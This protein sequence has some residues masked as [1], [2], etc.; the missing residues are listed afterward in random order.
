[1]FSLFGK[2]KNIGIDL[3]TVNTAVCLEKEGI[4]LREPTVVAVDKN[5]GRVLA[6]GA[7]ADEMLGR[8]PENIIAIRPL[9]DGVTADY[10]VACE[11]LKALM[12]KACGK[13]FIK[14]N[15]IVCVPCGITDVE[16]KAAEDAIVSAGAKKAIVV[17][18][19]MAAAVGAGAEVKKPVGHMIADIGGG[20]TEAAVIS[21]SG[22]VAAKSLRVGGK[23]IDGAIT[24]YIKRVHNVSIGEKTAEEVKI[25]IGSAM[26]EE[27]ENEYEVKGRDLSS[28][29]PK[30]LKL[31]SGEIREAM[32][33][34]IR[35][36]VSAVL[37]ALERVPPELAGDILE[38][39][40]TLT[41]GGAL[42]KGMDRLV[43]AV[44]GLPTKVAENPM[45]CTALGMLEAGCD[46]D[47][48]KR[49]SVS[50]LN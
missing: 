30:T 16:R 46:E 38:N 39:G 31:T 11:L 41:G 25:A 3:G 4:V 44:T 6:A 33:E 49:S 21:L 42:I 29:L 23:A 27:C 36:I 9:R 26:P 22:I 32:T 34:P 48:L 15:V 28:G 20:T 13:R 43:H 37:S 35:E 2:G 7:E 17:E 45:D 18:K 10:E 24:S 40:I 12:A 50:E 1:M 5:D 8:T 14:P 47:V 19:V